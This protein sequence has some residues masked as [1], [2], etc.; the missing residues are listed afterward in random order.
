MLSLD[1]EK[2]YVSNQE[3]R[4]IT[5]ATSVVRRTKDTIISIFRTIKEVIVFVAVAIVLP[6]LSL[7]VLPD[8]DLIGEL[9]KHIGPTMPFLIVFSCY[10]IAG[11]WLVA[12]HATNGRDASSILKHT[13]KISE[14]IIPIG[15][16]GTYYA[17]SEVLSLQS[18]D[19]SSHMHAMYSTLIALV[20]YVAV[21][22]GSEFIKKAKPYPI[23][24][25]P[26]EDSLQKSSSDNHLIVRQIEITGCV[27]GV[28]AFIYYL[29]A[30]AI[31]PLP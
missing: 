5:E 30:S 28:S 14:W 1:K 17:L 12:F 15:M 13:E 11:L 24:D 16:I 22:I 4:V 19:F 2:D 7:R 3:E 23:Q 26:T 18:V 21:G 9:Y 29:I 27:I 10:A 25:N 6:W 20:I 31:S 8:I